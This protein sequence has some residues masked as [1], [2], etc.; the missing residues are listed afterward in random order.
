MKFTTT[1]LAATVA[2]FATVTASPFTT[3]P[4]AATKWA[5]GQKVVIKWT[6]QG[7]PSLTTMGPMTID[8]MTGANLK[9]ILVQN[10]A[11]NVKPTAK[12]LAVTVPK[13]TGP[14]GVFYFLRYTSD[15]Q[16]YF[17]TRFL[18]SGISGNFPGFNPQDLNATGA[19][20]PP[21]AAAA[22]A[23]ASTSS[24]V[25]V[26]TMSGASQAAPSAKPSGSATTTTSAAVSS[27]A[28]PL[29]GLAITFLAAVLPFMC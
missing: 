24:G 10:L 8:L 22:P 3:E 21:A 2:M 25:P 27:S 28:A 7:K 15:N 17:T 9:Q 1:Y 19:A 23:P 18:I 26:A 12:Q 11:T 16:V 13:F 29:A 4:V 14:S 5:A 6:D 20:A